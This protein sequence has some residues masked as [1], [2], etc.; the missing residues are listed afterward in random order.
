MSLTTVL[1]FAIPAALVVFKLAAL[2]VAVLWSVR[3]VLGSQHS[4]PGKRLLLEPSRIAD[5]K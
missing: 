2:A 3:A 4:N 1:L 5:R